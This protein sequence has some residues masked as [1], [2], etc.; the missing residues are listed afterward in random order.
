MH[1]TKWKKMTRTRRTI[2]Q[3]SCIVFHTWGCMIS[4][5]ACTPPLC[6]ITKR[7]M[8]QKHILIV[9]IFIFFRYHYLCS[10]L[11]EAGDTWQRWT[12]ISLWSY[13]CPYLKMKWKIYKFAHK[14][15]IIFIFWRLSTSL[16]A[17]THKR[18]WQQLVETDQKQLAGHCIR[19]I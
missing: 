2:N 8:D 12:Q 9:K 17:I 19:K 5:N 13:R 11:Q 16:S 1:S 15:H 14:K 10:M 4:Q 18:G 7:I 6:N 3:R